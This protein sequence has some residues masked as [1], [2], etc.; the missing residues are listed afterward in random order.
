M[1]AMR[2]TLII[3]V[4]LMKARMVAMAEVVGVIDAVLRKAAS[5]GTRRVWEPVFRGLLRD[6]PELW[7]DPN[8]PAHAA[9]LA[10]LREGQARVAARQLA[11]DSTLVREMTNL[12]VEL[13][14]DRLKI[15]D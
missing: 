3:M 14:Y 13:A 15:A 1:M 4:M 11:H 9:A 12:E 8:G 6:H 2:T 10:R 7:R 5:P